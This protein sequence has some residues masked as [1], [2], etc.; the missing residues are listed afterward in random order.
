MTK[1]DGIFAGINNF[2]IDSSKNQMT[3]I[4]NVA[5]P[6]FGIEK[7]LAVFE[8]IRNALLENGF[9]E[10]KGLI[11]QDVLKLDSLLSR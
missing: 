6:D 4:F 3:I 5:S 11:S 7:Y 9:Y 10:S 2:S 8:T 1:Q